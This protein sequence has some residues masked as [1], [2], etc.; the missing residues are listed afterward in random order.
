MQSTI[1]PQKQRN[2]F[3]S[4]VGFKEEMFCKDVLDLYF[5]NLFH[6][7]Q[8]L[9]RALSNLIKASISYLSHLCRHFCKLEVCAKTLQ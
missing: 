9:S 8:A 3:S 1:N 2:F 7:P 4:Y 6:V 5:T